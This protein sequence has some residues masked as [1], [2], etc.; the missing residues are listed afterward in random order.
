MPT[1]YQLNLIEVTPRIRRNMWVGG[2]GI[3]AAACAT[4]LLVQPFYPEGKNAFIA[5]M[6][7]IGAGIVAG[8]VLYMRAVTVPS[9]VS[10]AAT[11]L[12]VRDL[13]RDQLVLCLDYADIAAYRHQTFNST[14]E[15][16]LTCHNGERT[17]L[18][19]AANLDVK[20][21]FAR[22]AR[23]FERQLAQVPAPTAPAGPHAAARSVVREKSFLEKPVA[24]ALLLAATAVAGLLVWQVAAGH[25]AIGQVAGALVVYVS[26]VVAWRAARRQPN[27]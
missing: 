16:R 2:L 7:L 23:E 20:G 11:Q 8:L 15:L 14:E 12:T 9:L 10:L 25:L 24:T 26:F 5:A 4:Y 1:E 19:V 17:A 22:M 21:E 27:P 13:R 18:K 3:L 6:L